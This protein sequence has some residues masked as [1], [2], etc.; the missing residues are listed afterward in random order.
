MLDYRRYEGR[1]A[2]MGPHMGPH[3]GARS[4]EA[5]AAAAWKGGAVIA[6]AAVATV[7]WPGLLA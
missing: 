6:V 3:M 1:L 7:G 4:G 2:D 5:A